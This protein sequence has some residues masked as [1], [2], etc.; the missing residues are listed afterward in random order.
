[1]RSLSFSSIFIISSSCFGTSF[2]VISWNLF[3]DAL[4]SISNA[5]SAA[6][7]LLFSASLAFLSTE[8][9]NFCAVTCSSVFSFLCWNKL[10]LKSFPFLDFFRFLIFFALF[11]QVHLVPVTFMTARCKELISGNIVSYFYLSCWNSVM[12]EAQSCQAECFESWCKNIFVHWKLSIYCSLT[13]R[14]S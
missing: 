8:S 11:H 3:C 12:N 13:M 5:F 9:T 2:F 14:Q 4:D 7:S 10:F 6:T 1:M